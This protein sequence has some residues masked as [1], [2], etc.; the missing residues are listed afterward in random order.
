MSC[1]SSSSQTSSSITASLVSAID[2]N[3][4]VIMS[5]NFQNT[6][7]L[8]TANSP[9]LTRP[10]VSNTS[11]IVGSVCNLSRVSGPAMT[12]AWL[13]P[14]ASNT[15]FQP[16]VGS[17]Y[18]YQHS[19]TTMLSEVTGQSQ[20]PTSAA[21]YSGIFEWG[22]AQS[23]EKKSSSPGNFTGTLIDQDTANSSMTVTTQYDKASDANKVVPLSPSLPANFVQATP[24]QIPT[25]AYSMS[26]PYQEGSHVYYYNQNTLGPPLSGE[27]GF[28]LQSYGCVSYGGSGSSIC[29]P[30]MVMVLKK[31]QPTNILT[32]VS[33]SGIYYSMPAQPNREM[34]FQV[35]ETSMRTETSVELQPSSQAFCFPQT[36]D[37]LTSCGSINAQILENNPP[38]EL[39]D[40]SV[41][42][43]VQS[44]TNNLA[45]PQAP[46]QEQ[47]EHEN[48]NEIKTKLSKPVEAYHI[49]ID[50]RDSPLLPLEIPD[51]HQ[52]LECIK[53]LDQEEK[54]DS[55]N[56]NLVK[57]SLSF[58]NQGTLENRVE[59]SNGFVD[60]AAL[61]EN[62]ELPPIFNSLAEH[63]QS[64]FPTTIKANDMRD[65]KVNQ[66]Q[67]KS[68]IV[69]ELT[70]YIRKKKDRD[71]ELIDGA[72]KDKIQRHNPECL[73]EREMIVC[74][75]VSSDSPTVITT[76]HSTCKPPKAA[77]SR[78]SK[79]KGLGQEKTKNTTQNN[80]KK[81]EENKQT[82]NKVKSDEKTI[83]KM[84]R[85]RNQPE[86][87]QET[88][89]KPRTYLGMHMLQSVQVFHALGKKT[90]KK[91]GS[92]SCRALANLS[93]TKGSQYSAAIKS[94]LDTPHEG[95]GP[96]KTQ[97]KAQKEDSSAG[98]EC[99]SPSQYELPPPGKVKLIPLPF[100]NPD[101]PQPRPVPRRPQAFASRRPTG[102]YPHPNSAQSLAVNACQPASAN[103]SLISPAKP[104]RPI[105][106]NATLPGLT[107]PT[108][109]NV[110]QSAAARPAPYKTSSF[111][112][113]QR[114]PVSTTMAKFQPPPKSQ[115]QF[116]LQDFSLQPIPWRKPNVPEPVMSSPIT[117]EQRPEREAMK[118]KAQQER[119]HA[120]K[121]TSLGKVQ[122]FI[123]REREMEISQYYGYVM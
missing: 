40:I 15:S 78:A 9:Q 22:T 28:C 107:K 83:P 19:S 67:K 21:S 57:N 60:M 30:E 84:K 86:L 76:K 119:E 79:A 90:D 53:P 1:L 11:S 13:R 31:V 96:K 118:R 38:L 69:K 17:A 114:Q 26:L 61:V 3:S 44:S 106:F 123:E 68:R 89:K 75:A 71:S 74:S 81:V 55:E 73:L 51:I 113:F 58:E 105:S 97:V 82:R 92:S 4:S 80:S 49:P 16:L 14:S 121:Y 23:T 41:L 103:T 42:T 32:P 36:S 18:I 45:L 25:Q 65:A 10:V 8:G 48:L 93:T 120:A 63:H 85:K 50:N 37:F 62:I 117:K 47:I 88:F 72:P 116:L 34:S 100:L 110:S 104:A 108:Q 54:P 115:T 112:S 99:S 59:C 122:F 95:K 43:A 94:R 35:M 33:T 29:Q 109:P 6:S 91:I 12:S 39:G 56:A 7:L 46:N 64:K 66:G 20:I 27:R 87:S 5:E 2:V 24:S 52:F 98:N 111:T 77:Y 70:D 102:S 101:K